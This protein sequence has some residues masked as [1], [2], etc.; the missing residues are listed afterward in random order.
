MYE[1]K[2]SGEYY[3]IHGSLEASKT[4]NMI[5][6]EAFRPDLTE[7]RECIDT[8]EKH[9]KQF[10]VAELE[11]MNAEKR[12]AGV[13]VLKYEDFEKSDHVSTISFYLSTDL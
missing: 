12:Q 2:T 11:E 8:I 10:T 3:F 9:V 5:G 7:Y 6:L 4:L 1:T 13:P